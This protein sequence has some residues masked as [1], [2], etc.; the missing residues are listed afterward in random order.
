MQKNLNHKKTLNFR[1]DDLAKPR[2][3]D[4]L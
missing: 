3:N 1:R 2:K 4:D